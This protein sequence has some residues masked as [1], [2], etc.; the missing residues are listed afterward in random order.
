MLFVQHRQREHSSLVRA[1]TDPSREAYRLSVD[2][3]CV[4]RMHAI[5]GGG[6]INVLRTTAH[7]EHGTDDSRNVIVVER[8]CDLSA[9]REVGKCLERRASNEVVVKFDEFPVA[10]VPW[11]QVVVLHVARVKASAK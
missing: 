6:K 1:I 3:H 4:E 7:L 2:D 8:Q 9:M 10:Q 11:R 5:N